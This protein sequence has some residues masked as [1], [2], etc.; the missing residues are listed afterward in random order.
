MYIV[1]I[2]MFVDFGNCDWKVE[3]D[4][5]IFDGVMWY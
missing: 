5:D 2:M 4:G 3:F 1:E